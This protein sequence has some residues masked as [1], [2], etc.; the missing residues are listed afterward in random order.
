MQRML[1]KQMWSQANFLKKLLI[2][3]FISFVP[4]VGQATSMPEFTTDSSDMWVNSKPLK[5]ADLKGKIVLIEVLT[6]I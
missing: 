5:V 6:S 3:L 4:F 1:P 2:V